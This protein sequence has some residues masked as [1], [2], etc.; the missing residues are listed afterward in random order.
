MKTKQFK[1][2]HK[3][4]EKK[5]DIIIKNIDWDKLY[6]GKLD[7]N[8]IEDLA[9]DFYKQLKIAETRGL[10]IDMTIKIELLIDEIFLLH[11]GKSD[12]TKSE[13][14]YLILG[15]EFYTLNNKKEFILYLI[16]NYFPRFKKLDWFSVMFEDV[17]NIRNHMAHRSFK[18]SKSKVSKIEDF[19]L[20]IYKTVQNKIPTNNTLK[21]NQDTLVL[22]SKKMVLVLAVINEIKSLMPKG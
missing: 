8:K 3:D 17:I 2:P 21:I 15:R 22:I 12:E 6:L 11:F 20:N 14:R 1:K 9:H 4:Q 13:L 19:E 16:E 10:I 5:Q 7:N 18:Y